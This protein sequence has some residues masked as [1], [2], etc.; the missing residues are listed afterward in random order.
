MALLYIAK[1]AI[2]ICRICGKQG[3][4]DLHAWMVM[5]DLI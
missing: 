3:I 5:Q 1:V 4:N 2:V